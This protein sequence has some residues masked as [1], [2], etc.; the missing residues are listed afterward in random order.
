ME[1]SDLNAHFEKRPDIVSFLTVTAHMLVVFGPIYLCAI[2]G[3]GAHLIG[4]WLLFGLGMNGIINLM[5]ECAHYHV[6]KDKIASDFLGKYI[7]APLIFTN[8]EIYRKRHWEHH[9]H[10]GVEGETKDAYL[11]DIKGRH[12][13]FLLVR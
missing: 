3:P 13:F 7:I 5:H 4:A 11:I 10:L 12:I 2:W 6:F 1:K 9:K 8:F